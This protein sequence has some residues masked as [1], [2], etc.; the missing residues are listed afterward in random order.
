MREDYK[1]KGATTPI[2][3][4]I[5]ADVAEQVRTMALHTGLNAS[6]LANTALKRFIVH[7]MDFFPKVRY[8]AKKAAGR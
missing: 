1:L 8:P 2:E 6:E 7:H 4:H 5:E 3:F